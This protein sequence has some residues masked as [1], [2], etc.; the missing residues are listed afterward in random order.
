MENNEFETMEIKEE[1]IETPQGEEVV[2]TVKV[3]TKPVNNRA[4][5]FEY[6]SPYKPTSEAKCPGDDVELGMNNSDIFIPSTDR[7]A[8]IQFMKDLNNEKESLIGVLKSKKRN[9]IFYIMESIKAAGYAAYQ[10]SG[11]QTLQDMIDTDSYYNKFAYGSKDIGITPVGIQNDKGKID[12]ALLMAM[13][14]SNMGSGQ[15]VNVPLY[16]SGFRIVVTAPTLAELTTLD[17]KIYKRE[18]E[19]GRETA[20]LAT[21]SK[22]GSTIEILKEYI[23]GKITHCTLDIDL[24]SSDV[25][26]YISMLDFD[27]ILLA[28]LQATYTTGVPVTR[29]CQ[30]M[31][32]ENVA[33]SMH[34]EAKLDPSKLLVVDRSLLT[35]EMIQTI[36]K[37]KPRE[38]SLVERERYITLLNSRL[39]EIRERKPELITGSNRVEFKIP[40]VSEYIMDSNIWIEEIKKELDSILDSNTDITRSNALEKILVSTYLSGY[41]SNFKSLGVET[42]PGYYRNI[43]QREHIRTVLDK[44][45]NNSEVTIMFSEAVLDY[46]NRSYVSLV[47][48]PNYICPVCN[49][50]QDNMTSPAVDFDAFIPFNVLDFFSILVGNKI[51]KMSESQMDM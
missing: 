28:L 51:Q 41:L 22:R 48:T 6:E 13:F 23:R 33:C 1:V 3:E 12:P 4:D 25:F 15:T 42:E 40:T 31:S 36:A 19:I 8:M 17:L 50:K 20:C 47:A 30:N 45:N 24:E 9:E 27:T 44:I 14:Q 46:I 21:N 49:K 37:R 29:S 10:D 34:V 18:V 26:D 7:G 5:G 35:T 11:K 43:E 39:D 38:V 2:E 32:N 16:H